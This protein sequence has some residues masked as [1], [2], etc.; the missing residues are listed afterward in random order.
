ML[1]VYRVFTNILYPFLFLFV[2][3]RVL[4]KKEDSKRYKE[5]LLVKNFNVR[6]SYNKKLIWFHAA[7]IG[8]FKSIIP[9][10][11]KLNINKKEYQFLITT[12]TI[13]SGNLAENELK[14]F[15][16]AQHRY[17]PFDV[18]YLV[19]K[20][21][22]IWKPEKIFLVDSEIWPNLILKANEKKIPLCLVN[23]RLTEKSYKR[24][25]TFPKTSKKIFSLINLCLCSNQET[26]NRLKNLNA[27]N[28]K[29]FGNIKFSYKIEPKKLII[30]NEDILSRS[31]FWL[32]ASIHNE[33]YVFCLKTHCEIKKKYNDIITMIAPRHLNNIDKI[34]SLS[35][36]LNLKTQILNNNEKIL[37][38]AEV[39]IIN[40]FGVLQ[41]YYNHAKSVFIGKSTIKSLQNDSGQNP[42][43]AAKLNCKIYH[44]PYV[45]NFN[46]VYE[47]LKDKKLSISIKDYYELSENLIKDLK[48]PQKKYNDKPNFINYLGDKILSNT[49]F[50]IDNFIND[51]I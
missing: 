47:I 27:N 12:T 18:N 23:A 1:L 20:F 49:M 32:A 48:D 51:K 11:E 24:W 36:N 17:I 4:L 10:I 7:S 13:T 29:F 28:V 14:R 6:K 46:E 19:D 9:I 38:N 41:K 26:Q 44:G 50:Q 21:L 43:D 39:I 31:R 8:E 22:D 30:Y 40:S 5:K 25:L 34:K 37:E 2:Y 45:S 42:I 15:N 3:L 35:E 16:N 33:E